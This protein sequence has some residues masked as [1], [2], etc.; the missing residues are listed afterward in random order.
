VTDTYVAYQVSQT[1]QE[2]GCVT[3]QVFIMAEICLAAFWSTIPC[4]MAVEYPSLHPAPR[5]ETAASSFSNG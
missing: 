4:T 1:N 2:L 3:L 5:G